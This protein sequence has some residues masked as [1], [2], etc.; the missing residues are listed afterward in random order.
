MAVQPAREPSSPSAS[1]FLLRCKIQGFNIGGFGKICYPEITHDRKHQESRE[2]TSRKRFLNTV[3]SL[4]TKGQPATITE[5]SGK[6]LQDHEMVLIHSAKKPNRLRIT[7]GFQE[8][9]P[10]KD[11]K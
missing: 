11:V 2:G 7:P 4:P 8:K 1:S 3:A 5:F 6:W 9:L 10:R